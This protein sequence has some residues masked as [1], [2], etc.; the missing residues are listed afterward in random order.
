MKELKYLNKYLF[1]YRVSLF[2]GVLITIIARIF[3]LF[4]PRLIGNSLTAVERFILDDAL[5]LDEIKEELFWNIVIIV[6]AALIS[7]FLTFLMRQTIINVSRYIEFDLKNEIFEHYQKLCLSFYKNNRTGD[8]MNRISE[9]VGKVRM[10]FGPAI[11]YSINTIALFVIVISYMV[12]IAPL[13]TVYTL[14]PLPILSLA[15]YKLSK[16]INTRS[17][18][19]QETLSDL[20]TFTQESFSGIAVIKSYGIQS[21]INEDFAQLTT[22]SKEKNVDLAKIQAWFFPLMI[23]L[24]GFSN[25]LVIFVGGNQYIEGT[26][27]IGVLA[28]FIIYVNMLTWPVATVGWVTSIVQQA[29]ASQ[30]RINDFLKE[31]PK[32]TSGS[33]D[34]TIEKGTIEFK[35][36]SF[37]YKETQIQAAKN[38]SFKLN[39]GETLGII[40]KTGSGK[41]TLLDLICRLYDV[42]E[43]EI[44][45]DGIPIQDYNLLGIR[46]EIGYVPQNP[47]LFSESIERNIRFGKQDAHFDEIKAAAQSAAVAEN[48]E[49][50]KEGYKTLLGERGVTLSGGQIQRISIAR[51]LI[52]DP[53]V[54]LFDD[55]LSAVDADTEEEILKN[56]KERSKEKTTLI[57]SHRISSVKDANSILVID[58][59]AII[60]QG[61]HVELIHKG[62]FYKELFQK[63]NTERHQ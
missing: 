42:D 50:F 49:Q 21:K 27:E 12:S 47:F 35:K 62:G 37:T 25:L 43:G 40:G 7:G 58:Q 63:Q 57:V 19:V 60:E 6:S 45:I 17:T 22:L 18:A 26:L 36:V 59:G 51:A 46:S 23:L 8:L 4:A 44:L 31:E 10:Y 20:S 13:L 41:S 53:K 3:S 5:S 38:I 48:I 30:K 11:M 52:K 55:C 1:K 16:A 33:L 34:K 61:T 2:L 32:I 56:L 28:E 15:I 24:I 9:D 39:P 54:L 14:L 29:E